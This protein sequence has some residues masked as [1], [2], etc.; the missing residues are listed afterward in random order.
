MIR[1]IS[2]LVRIG[3]RGPVFCGGETKINN[4]VKI[5]GARQ[6]PG[7]K[8]VNPHMPLG[9]NQIWTALLRGEGVGVDLYQKT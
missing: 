3:I 1:S 4:P 6:E 2:S 9:R 8:K 5:L 7:N